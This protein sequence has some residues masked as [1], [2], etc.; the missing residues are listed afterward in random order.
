MVQWW[1]YTKTC[2]EFKKE[3]D[4]AFEL[5]KQNVATP[6]DFVEWF[7][8]NWDLLCANSAMA[9]TNNTYN[10][11]LSY[12]K[13]TLKEVEVSEY[14]LDYTHWP[15]YKSRTGVLKKRVPRCKLLVSI[16]YK[17]TEKDYASCYGNNRGYDIQAIPLEWAL[18]HPNVDDIDSIASEE[19][20][21]K[22]ALHSI[23]ETETA[24]LTLDPK[25]WPLLAAM[26]ALQ[27]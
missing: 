20:N 21:K 15:S 1:V 25:E 3:I 4:Q 19:N 9:F 2:N 27:T 12:L 11:R 10:H 17:Y 13:A 22:R 7:W 24:W 16:K 14:K 6:E 23:T 18:R 5:A 26:L 8:T